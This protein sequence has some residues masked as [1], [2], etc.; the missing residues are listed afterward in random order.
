MS[1]LLAKLW[2]F[3]E[4]SS[5]FSVDTITRLMGENL[6]VLMN[7]WITEYFRRQIQHRSS[8]G[9]RTSDYIVAAGRFNRDDDDDRRPP[10]RA[11][12]QQFVQTPARKSATM[13]RLVDSPYSTNT[14]A[15]EPV[16][17]SR[18]LTATE[19]LWDAPEIVLCHHLCHG[20]IFNQENSMNEEWHLYCRL[21][22]QP[23]QLLHRILWSVTFQLARRALG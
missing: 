8:Q 2:K 11:G 16:K 7:H 17:S 5:S 1:F 19:R 4:A 9:L 13:M 21:Q 6:W 20:D 10:R 3:A 22:E 15:K 18:D 12:L 14:L 23:S